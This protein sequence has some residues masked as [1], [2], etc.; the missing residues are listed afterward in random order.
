MVINKMNRYDEVIFKKP[1]KLLNLHIKKFNFMV[2]AIEESKY[3]EE[4]TVDKV[5]SML[6]R[7]S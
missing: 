6:T 3:L 5:M 4:L 7:R 2:V 1:K